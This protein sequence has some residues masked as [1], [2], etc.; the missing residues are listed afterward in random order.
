MEYLADDVID[1]DG[2]HLFEQ[3]IDVIFLV[4]S[5]SW[6]IGC[7]IKR[8]WRQYFFAA[9]IA[10]KDGK[11][12]LFLFVNI[13]LKQAHCILRVNKFIPHLAEIFEED[14][15]QIHGIE[16]FSN[17][18]FIVLEVFIHLLD[19]LRLSSFFLSDLP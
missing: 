2:A 10:F 14:G 18:A 4:L 3:R 6:V 17:V 8:G 5:L 12:D 15:V 9:T 11:C 13:F 16:H 1:V 19:Y 7:F